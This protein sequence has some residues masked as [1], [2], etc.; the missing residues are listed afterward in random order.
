MGVPLSATYTVL[1]S[2]LAWMPRGRL[3]TSMVSHHLEGGA[4]DHRDVAGAFVGD[5]D[6][7]AGGGGHR[8]QQQTKRGDKQRAP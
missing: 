4:V 2:G 3:P 7:I 6:L 5:V 8:R 1:P